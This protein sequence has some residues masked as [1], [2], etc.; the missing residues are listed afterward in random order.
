MPYPMKIQPVDSDVDVEVKPVAAAPK[1]QSLLKRLFEKQFPGLRST[2]TAATTVSVVP[3]SRT[4]VPIGIES[5]KDVK[6]KGVNDFE[7]SSICLVKMVQNFL[8]ESSEKS[9]RCGHRRCHCFNGNCDESS[10][11][12]DDGDAYDFFFVDTNTITARRSSAC[13]AHLDP[14]EILKSLVLC[15]TTAEKNLLT[16]TTKVMEMNRKNKGGIGSNS[17]KIDVQKRALVKELIKLGFDSAICKSRCETTSAFLAGEYEYIDVI[18]D[19]DGERVLIDIDFKSE[20]EIARPTKTY[21]SLVSILPTI[22]V[23]KPDRVKQ[24]VTV[25]SDAAKQ[26]M[27]KKG[28]HIPPWRKPEYMRSKWVSPH[29]RLSPPRPSPL[30]AQVPREEKEEKEEEEEEGPVV[31]DGGDEEKEKEKLM[32]EKPCGLDQRLEKSGKPEALTT[33]EWHPPA[34]D[35][36]PMI[37]RGGVKIVTGLGSIV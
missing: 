32:V 15:A 22:F 28:L 4:V 1:P 20:F 21:R 26:S 27:K 7:P 5:L 2:T 36:K 30:P 8:E 17:T 37:P 13:S 12:D 33:T 16:E 14:S 23:G 31:G 35:P 11:S 29:Q 18:M 25:M 3:R 10:S 34:I 19:G 24:I 6:E 9:S